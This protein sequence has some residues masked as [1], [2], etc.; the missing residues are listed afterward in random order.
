[1]NKELKKYISVF[2]LFSFLFSLISP[3]SSYAIF[4]GVREGT[5][6]DGDWQSGHCNTGSISFD[7]FVSN[8]D[9]TWQMSN[10]VCIGFMTGVGL[11]MMGAGKL[12]D[13]LC[14]PNNI[15]GKAR[16]QAQKAGNQV[17]DIPALTP[18][19]AYK[20]AYRAGFCA[21][22]ASDIA[23]YSFPGGQG[24]QA[25]AIT[26]TAKCCGGYAI[27]AAAVGVA[28]GV[29]RSIH[30]YSDKAFKNVRVCGSAWNSW[31]SFDVNGDPASSG[32]LY[33]RRGGYSGS[34]QHCL[35]SVFIY[36]QDV[37]NLA[38]SNGISYADIGVRNK[39]YREYI[40]GGKEY[41]DSKCKNPSTISANDF[42][43]DSDYQRYYMKG[44]G[45]MSN[46][47]CYRFLIKNN[48]PEY[49]EAYECC[50]ERSQ[51][52]ICLDSGN[53][54][55]F[56][57]SG[58]KCD[59]KLEK[60]GSGAEVI[61]VT[62]QISFAKTDNNFLCAE[63]YSVC[64]YNHKL[65]GGTEVS[66]YIKDAYQRPTSRKSNY[67][68]VM[69]HCAK[70]PILPY[71]KINTLTNAFISSSC[72]DMKGSSQNTY[73]YNAQ[74][75]PLKKITNFSAPIAECFKET[76]Q[77]M[78]LNKA[79]DSKCR[80]PDESPDSKGNCKSGYFYEKGN[81][82]NTKS[83]F[84]KVQDA[85]KFIIKMVL[86]LSIAFFGA[87][88]LLGAGS[89]EK[90]KLLGYIMKIGLI[91]YFAL[92]TGW[93]D[94]LVEGVTSTST[95]LGDIMMNIDDRGG[96]FSN[97][98]DGCIFPKY[99]SKLESKDV[100]Y[101]D[102]PQYPKGLEYLKIWDTL[103]CKLVRALGLGPDANVPNL[104]LMIV[105][106][107]FTGAF[108]LVFLFGA[109]L[110][111]VMF[112]SLILKALHMFLMSTVTLVILIYVSPVVI[113]LTLFEKTKGIF[114]SWLK[115]VIGMILQPVILFAYLGIFISIFEYSVIGEVE[116]KGNGREA[117]KQ[118]VCNDETENT[119]VYC[120]FRVADIK[121]WGALAPI[122][123]AIPMLTSMN[124]EKVYSIL[125]AAILMFIFSAFMDKI[126]E[127][128]KEL[129]GGASLAPSSNSMDATSIMGKSYGGA[130]AIQKRGARAGLKVANKVKRA[131]GSIAKNAGRLV[132]H[133][134]RGAGRAESK[135]IANIEKGTNAVDSTSSSTQGADATTS[136]P[137]TP[138]DITTSGNTKNPDVT[139][140]NESNV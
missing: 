34:Y 83:P 113:T 137:V 103:D 8:D 22:T 33:W 100:A 124:S 87:M 44:A 48:D 115:Q 15:N 121:T 47:A 25:L 116:Y 97:K 29:L 139:G 125:K 89:L 26:D 90:K 110:F 58:K 23:F 69:N 68:Q 85:L 40:Y 27:Y 39:L 66:Q 138:D 38:N 129:V 82:L 104:V 10:P 76:L 24:Q 9:I 135:N 84:V 114:S 118:I 73:S 64:P 120:I 56:C 101:Y 123:I 61:P 112:F 122:G 63:T 126:Y 32:E 91:T 130:R 72:K 36:G 35:E 134:V 45:V 136:K 41:E 86:T 71:V 119:S 46:Y 98:S 105:A 54:S 52:T 62:Y 3:Y 31:K 42:G 5:Y 12:T 1:M 67:C 79:G 102:N 70:V 131:A 18:N 7:P 13:I 95:Y 65:G 53:D 6:W 108:G 99:N 107:L 93:Q 88:T 20:L 37:C 133:G 94:V 16:Y 80:N 19:V 78:L 4:D 21:A 2:L 17:P 74:I 51:N 59:I 50:K 127:I 55:V 111:A 49:R 117:P 140:K 81:Y 106:G 132:K 96:R 30:S 14:E 109:F 92:G 128:A 28:V 43:Y 57:E 11:T 75:T 60:F 77:N